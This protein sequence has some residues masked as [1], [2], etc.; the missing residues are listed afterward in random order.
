[1]RLSSP[2]FDDGASIP[3]RFTAPDAN[4]LPPLRF[5][6]VPESAL[7]LALVL[8]DLDSPLGQ[9]TH[10]L[11][12]NLP[13]DTTKLGDEPLPEQSCIGLDTFGETGYR[14]PAPAEGR[15]R[16]RFRL[17]ALD[18]RLALPDGATRRDFELAI[19]DH[20]LREATLIGLCEAPAFDPD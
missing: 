15:H 16:Y 18:C 9:V 14:G 12:W 4:E 19:R 2:S 8:D 11:V 6:E 5:D 20:V 10:W 17:I 1:M 3:A 13:P 7:S